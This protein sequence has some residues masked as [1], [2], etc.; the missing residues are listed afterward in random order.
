MWNAD[1]KN[2]I[3]VKVGL[4]ESSPADREKAKRKG[5]WGQK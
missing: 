4:F 3:D 2:D 1:L 5:K